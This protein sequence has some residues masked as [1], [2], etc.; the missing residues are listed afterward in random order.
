MEISFATVR[1]SSIPHSCAIAGRW[2]IEL[3]E[4][5]SAM[6]TASA[7]SKASRVMRSRGRTFSRTRSIT[8]MPESFAKRRRADITAGI[9]PFPGSAIPRTS[10]K[11]FIEFA[12]NIPEQD[13]QDGQHLSSISM[14]I[15]F[16]IRPAWKAPTASATSE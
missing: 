11:Q 13:P 7:F 10:V 8:R 15:V 14:K 2:S 12:V 5:P 9:V 16:V 1:S 3:V 6:S 4:H